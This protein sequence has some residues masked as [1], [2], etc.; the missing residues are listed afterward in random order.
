[1]QLNSSLRKSTY[2]MCLPWITDSREHGGVIIS[3]CTRPQQSD[4]GRLLMVIMGANAYDCRNHH[5]KGTMLHVTV[6]YLEVSK[7]VTI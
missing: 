4:N 5:Y 2:K 1:M 6:H 7:C 3:V